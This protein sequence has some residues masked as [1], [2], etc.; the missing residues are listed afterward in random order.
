[1]S[2]CS[3]ETFVWFGSS[4]FYS[5]L[6][7]KPTWTRRQLRTWCTRPPFNMA[8]KLWN[9]FNRSITALGRWHTNNTRWH[10]H[11]MPMRGRP[12]ES[13][14]LWHRVERHPI[15]FLLLERLVAIAFY[16]KVFWWRAMWKMPKSWLPDTELKSFET[17]ADNTP[18]TLK[19]PPNDYLRGPY[20]SI[21]FIFLQSHPLHVT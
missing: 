18:S 20:E 8:Q 11:Y 13:C 6:L 15:R 17:F 12:R 3:R 19:G 1:M 7:F 16:C 5:E 10:I 21:A 9:S 14:G 4:N 2:H